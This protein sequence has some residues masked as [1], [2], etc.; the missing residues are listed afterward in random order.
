MTDALAELNEAQQRLSLLLLIAS[1]LDRTAI[2][3]AAER[4]RQAER[5]ALEGS[6]R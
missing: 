2:A 4:V 5:R 6:S 3:Q 1:P